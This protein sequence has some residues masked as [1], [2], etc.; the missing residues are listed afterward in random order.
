VECLLVPILG[1][2]RCVGVSRKVVCL[3]GERKLVLSMTG[4]LAPTHVC[5]KLTAA[6][7]LILP[8]PQL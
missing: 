3:A 4:C 8:D 5:W 7:V 1:Q 6:R 2:V